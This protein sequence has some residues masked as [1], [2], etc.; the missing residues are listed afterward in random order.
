M[1]PTEIQRLRNAIG[2]RY[3]HH[4]VILV[5][6]HNIFLRAIHISSIS[7]IRTTDNDCAENMFFK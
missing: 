2:T 4:N 1:L 7:L 3:Y 5:L 6:E